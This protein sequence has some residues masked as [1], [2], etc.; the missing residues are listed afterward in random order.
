MRHRR[1]G[2]YPGSGRSPGGGQSNPLQYSCLEN[3][4]DRGAWRATVHR[5]TES[6][7]TE[8]LSLSTQFW[9]L[10]IQEQGVGK[11][12]PGALRG[13]RPIFSWVLDS[14]GTSLSP[15]SHGHLPTSLLCVCLLFCLFQAHFGCRAHPDLR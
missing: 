15:S 13:T 7:T 12:L 5:V 4:M 14:L 3:P 6:D 10:E 1:L 11:V 9:R 2:F 8:R